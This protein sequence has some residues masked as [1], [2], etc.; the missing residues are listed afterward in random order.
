[1]KK[2]LVLSIS[3]LALVGSLALPAF[4]A[5]TT[6]TT[7]A[8]V[9]GTV[10]TPAADANASVAANSSTTLTVN[11]VT[12]D[13]PFGDIVID[14]TKQPADADLAALTD[15]Q[16]LELNSRCD[17]INTNTA[18]Y[19]ADTSFWC[20]SYADWYKKSHPAG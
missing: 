2:Q 11:D 12:K 4:A 17:I 15:A 6:A 8:T 9:N 7:G 18:N 1:M 3:A 20:K 13:K 19:D 16:K 5:S 10:T 14:K